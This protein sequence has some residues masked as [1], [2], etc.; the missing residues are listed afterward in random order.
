[1]TT[2]GK[3][4]AYLYDIHFW[5]GK[6]SS[7]DESGTAAIK[8]VEL[9]SILGGRA[10]QHREL[11]GFESDKLLSYF[12][13]CIIPLEGGFASGFRK[14][15]EEKF[16]TRLYVCRGKRVVRMKQEPLVERKDE[17]KLQVWCINSSAKSPVPKEEI[18]KFYSGDCYIVLYTYHSGEKK[19]DY[20][21]TCWMGNDSIQGCIFQGK[22]PPQFIALFQPMVVLKG[23]ISSGYKEFIAEKNLNDE[24]YTSDGIALMQVS[25]AS[26]HNNKA[27]QVDAVNEVFN[28]SQDDLL[29]EDMLLFD[30]HAEVF[31]WIGHSVDS[32]E[33]QNAF[34][35]GQVLAELSF[36]LSY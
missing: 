16:E 27:V 21:L 17:E 8:T 18:G 7:Q 34:D 1:Q 30:T 10:V 28:Y 19:E 15:E 35:I 6:E 20:F 2:S 13:P 24:T 11:Q 36:Y 26:V 23:G 14:P 33:K 31:V 25:G 12:K 3:G 22:E 29:T 9:D 4:G 32:N 5:I